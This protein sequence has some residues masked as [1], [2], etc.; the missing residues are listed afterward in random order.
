V[1]MVDVGA[2]ASTWRVAVARGRVRLSPPVVALLEREGGRGPKGDVWTTAQVA[3]IY[4]AKHAWELVPLAHPV[5]LTRVDI[6][7]SLGPPGVDIEAECAA[8]GPTGV[9]M[10]ALS[11][12][13]GAALAVYDMLKAVDRA[14][15]VEA[16]RLVYKSGGRSGTYLRP[17][18]E[19]P[20][21]AG[22]GAP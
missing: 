22:G 10:E 13:M 11:A 16:V 18:E 5:A 17:G 3:G 12:V 9:E 1:R 21:V 8:Q 2:K 20:A 14:M 4:A 19:P 6:R 7:L 15:V